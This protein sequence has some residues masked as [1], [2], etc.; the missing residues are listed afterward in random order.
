MALTERQKRG[1]LIALGAAA[2]AAVVAGVAEA[3]R[4]ASGT[5][6]TGST[7]GGGSG[8]SAQAG[9]GFGTPYAAYVGG[10]RRPSGIYAAGGRILRV[11][12]ARATRVYD[13]TVGGSSLGA[14]SAQQG[15]HL[16][17]PLRIG[18]SGQVP[19]WYAVSGLI[20]EGGSAA[21]TAQSLAGLGSAIVGGHL[22]AAAGSSAALTG[23]VG[24]GQTASPQLVSEGQLSYTGY[25]YGVWVTAHI[26]LDSAMT[27]EL[28][29]SPLDIWSAN[30]FVTV[31]PPSASGI[32]SFGF[33]APSAS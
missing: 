30:A 19:V 7:S 14:V 27:Q 24:A 17:V 1:G 5:G 31:T 32:I 13:T 29:G 15:Q 4:N 16:Y 21:G 25:P 10:A 20:W 11:T 18:N 22:T 3:Q 23:S 6:G 33:G 12:G 2:V 28:P 9:I 8:G 26:Y